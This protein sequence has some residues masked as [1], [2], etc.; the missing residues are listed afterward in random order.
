MATQ[1][2][3]NKALAMMNSVA[4]QRGITPTESAPLD[5]PPTD[6]PSALDEPYTNE[7]K[8]A[9]AAMIESALPDNIYR[10]GLR[11]LVQIPTDIGIDVGLAPLEYFNP[12]VGAK[13]GEAVRGSVKS[14]QQGTTEFGPNNERLADADVLYDTTGRAHGPNSVGG[15]AG[16][17]GGGA[18]GSRGSFGAFGFVGAHVKVN[19]F[20]QRPVG[21]V[22]TQ[23]MVAG[24]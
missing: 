9:A 24:V 6:D 4:G 13:V 7:Q 19:K 15:G 14:R 1:E 16:L 11:N 2:E 21:R 23:P 22:G 18:L 10:Q 17:Q 12:E 5:S 20:E 8:R 3:R